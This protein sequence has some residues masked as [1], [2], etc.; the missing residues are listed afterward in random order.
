M[1]L[2]RIY[3]PDDQARYTAALAAQVTAWTEKLRGQGLPDDLLEGFAKQSAQREVDAPAVI[4]FVVEHTGT[5]RD[6]HF[7]TSFVTDGLRMGAI[8]IEGNTLTLN[9]EPEPLTYEILRRPGR[10]CLHCGEKLE[11][12]ERG[13]LARLHVAE[14]HAGEVAPGYEAINYFDC[15]LD[16]AQHEQYKYGGA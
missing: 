7:S 14:Q 1:L 16:A 5:T 2:K 15:V 10:Y 12:D 4:G 8:A 3:N 6:Q 9:V 11:N 13:E